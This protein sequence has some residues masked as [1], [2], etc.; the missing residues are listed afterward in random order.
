MY[1]KFNVDHH[2]GFKMTN[3]FSSSGAGSYLTIANDPQVL[4]YCVDQHAS[5]VTDL[6]AMIGA[7]NFTTILEFQPMPSYYADIG[8]EKGGNML[9]L[10]QNVGNA[11]FFVAGLALTSQDSE[12]QYPQAYQ[13]VN[14]M[15]QNIAAFLKSV[16]RTEKVHIHEL[17]ALKSGCA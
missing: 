9:G 8:K 6:S 15:V 4:R 3:C 12:E 14:A 10:E 16:G 2:Y 13:R 17:R 7:E 5:L 11:L 1:G